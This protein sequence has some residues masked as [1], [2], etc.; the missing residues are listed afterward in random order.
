MNVKL[1]SSQGF[2]LIEL[3]IVVAILGIIASIATPM[4]DNHIR[5]AEV[6]KAA[7]AFESAIRLAKNK[8]YT[9]GRSITICGTA[10][11]TAT[12]PTC[13]TDLKSAFYWKST[14]E[15]S[16]WIVYRDKNN[17]KTIES[18]EV[19]DK[20]PFSQRQVGMTWNGASQIELNP[21]NRTGGSGTLC[22]YAPPI[23]PDPKKQEDSDKPPACSGTTP[24][25][26]FYEVEV[27]LSTLGNV[28]I[29]K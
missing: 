20:S 28:T 19:I 5:R 18:G 29:K 1:K 7:R 27:T 10:D 25:K 22:V 26:K 23:D 15:K 9:S 4:Y 3:I 8:A 12:A 13:A 14:N 24:N 17:N 6:N 11:T 16:G 21:R 2:T